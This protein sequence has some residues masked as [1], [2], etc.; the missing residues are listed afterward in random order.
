[1]RI[2]IFQIWCSFASTRGGQSPSTKCWVSL[3][4]I[5]S[6]IFGTCLH[7]KALA[8]LRKDN[9][10]LQQGDTH[11]QENLAPRSCL[12]G[13][14]RRGPN[15]PRNGV[16]LHTES[17]PNKTCAYFLMR[18]IRINCGSSGEAWMMM[19]RYMMA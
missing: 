10:F 3:I 9:L 5:S 15:S 12:S 14:L 1:M 7:F 18:Y 6:A 19:E 17:K 2:L 11:M 13:L 8:N 16:L 4:L